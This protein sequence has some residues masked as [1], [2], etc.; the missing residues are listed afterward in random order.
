M[1]LRVTV[2]VTLMAAL[3]SAA[4]PAFAQT[5]YPAE[6]KKTAALLK[7]NP[8]SQTNRV[9]LGTLYYLS[10]Y[11]QAQAGKHKAAIDAYKAGLDVLEEKG[12]A[13][14]EN[15]PVYQGLRYGLAFSLRHEGR[16]REAVAVLDQLV[17]QFPDLYKGRYLLGVTLV[18]SGLDKDVPRGIEVLT[19][20]AHDNAGANA[21]MARR[22]ALRLAL[23]YGTVL[24]S[25][26]RAKEAA[27]M[28]LALNPSGT[29][30]GAADREEQQR[31]LY[32]AGY[33]K[34]Q[35][36]NTPAAIA[37]LE[38]L[39]Q[40]NADYKLQNGITLQVVLAGAYYRGGREQ[41]ENNGLEAMKLAV[42]LLNLAE[43]T[44]NPKAADVNYGKAVAY[45]KMGKG[46][47]REAAHELEVAMQKDPD[48]L[49]R[50]MAQR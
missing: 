50:L 46:H 5:D 4:A 17:R 32:A 19:R 29:M 34:L 20:L 3:L 39:G 7:D 13:I 37:D 30:E 9:R 47:E 18:E 33:F 1:N 27:A 40:A 35:A 44:G 31:L 10:G 22:A 2:T 11:G 24:T 15:N 8:A 43:K 28:M 49:K 14:P 16:N 26:G 36:G 48:Y 42:E 12:H 6:I 25:L 45:L 23:D 38:V 21:Q 41:L